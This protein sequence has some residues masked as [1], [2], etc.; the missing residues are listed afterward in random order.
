MAHRS[1]ILKLA[2]LLAAFV[3]VVVAVALTAGA[4]KAAPYYQS[5]DGRVV[6][7]LAPSG[8]ADLVLEVV[9]SE[10]R[11]VDFTAFLSGPA[12]DKFRDIGVVKGRGRGRIAIGEYVAEAA[13][14]AK[15]LGYKPN[16]VR[17]GI[18]AFITTI[19]KQGNE[20]YLLTDIISIPV[21]PGEAV[22]R[23]VVAKVK[24]K[25]RFKVKV[26]TGRPPNA[27][28]DVAQAANAQNTPPDTMD[29]GCVSPIGHTTC[30][31]YRATETYSS[32]AEGVP[33]LITRVDSYDSKYIYAV[34]H[35]HHIDLNS[36]TTTS[37]SFEMSF[38][39]FKKDVNNNDFEVQAIGPG[40]EIVLGQQ[41]KKI[42]LDLSCRFAPGTSAVCYSGTSMFTP[43]NSY[44]AGDSILATG[45]VGDVRAVKY[46]L[47]ERWCYISPSGAVY[48]GQWTPTSVEAWGVWLAGLWGGD[49]F[50][51]YAEV[52]NSPYSRDDKLGYLYQSM[53]ELYQLGKV[54]TRW[55]PDYYVD[56]YSISWKTLVSSSQSS[57]YFAIGIPAGAVINWVILK[58]GVVLPD[59]ISKGLD[60]LSVGVSV[61]TSR[62]DVFSYYATLDI[63]AK[64]NVYWSPFY[65]ELENYYI[66][67]EDKYYN[68][69]VAIVRP[70]I[71]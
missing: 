10:G 5:K 12:V 17:F 65:Y 18:V 46:V 4:F 58:R 29:M 38:A 20:T 64:T 33:L 26:D 47:E 13:Q 31:R 70:Y 52:S 55:L 19:E 62:I 22:G 67:M 35:K 41:T 11:P 37:I 43:A 9:D 61:G 71:W 28:G 27:A 59:R 36:Q 48:C 68:V 66:K 50:L 21:G 1:R 34:L 16:E 6:A 57:N 7:Y 8:G 2:A 39:V 60:S 69:P 14:L 42:L 40:F 45:L 15:K 63:I 32:S 51:L 44:Y 23:E 53:L 30:Y 3:A 49:S 24:F 56:Y 25:P 54:N